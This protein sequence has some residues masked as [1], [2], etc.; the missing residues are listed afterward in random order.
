MNMFRVFLWLPVRVGLALWAWLWGWT[1]PLA[2]PSISE[3][4]AASGTNRFEFG[5]VV[6]T[7][8][9]MLEL[10]LMARAQ[11]H[12]ERSAATRTTYEEPVVDER[13]SRPLSVQRWLTEPAWRSTLREAIIW[14]TAASW[15]VTW[16]SIGPSFIF[17]GDFLFES[18]ATP[19]AVGY[20]T[21]YFKV[22]ALALVL[23]ASWLSTGIGLLGL[24]RH[25]GD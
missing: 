13:A 14:S 22:A 11:D 24:T 21:P 19:D 5:N 23:P 10:P 7:L 1:Y 12:A 4:G 8:R 17:T 15:L 18:H 16:G 6:S 2:R 25:T 3:V 20:V 9:F